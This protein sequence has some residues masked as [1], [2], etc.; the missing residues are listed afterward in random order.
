MG[1]EFFCGTRCA[2]SN[3]VIISF[4]PLQEQMT[5][6]IETRS[7]SLRNA[8]GTAGVRLVIMLVIYNIII[9]LLKA[10]LGTQF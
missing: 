5:K 7:V 8:I 2:F 6:S 1:A 3:K 10:H 9:L 4:D